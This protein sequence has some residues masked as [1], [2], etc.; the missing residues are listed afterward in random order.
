MTYIS[1]KFSSVRHTL[2][3][4]VLRGCRPVGRGGFSIHAV[5]VL[6]RWRTSASGLEDCSRW[7][8]QQRW[9]FVRGVPLLFSARPDLHVPQNG[10]RLGRRASPSTVFKPIWLSASLQF[11]RD[12]YSKAAF[13]RQTQT[14]WHLSHRSKA[15]PACP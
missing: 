12:A 8:Q 2:Q 3:H 4:K 1:V 9:N 13:G 15:L 7:P 14:S 10:D 6:W 11:R 5:T